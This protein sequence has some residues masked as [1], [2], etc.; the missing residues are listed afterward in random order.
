MATKANIKIKPVYQWSMP[1]LLVSSLILVVILSFLVYNNLTVDYYEKYSSLQN[2]E[3]NLKQQI[4]EKHSSIKKVPI[5][6]A[7]MAELDLL[8]STVNKQFPDDD[9]IPNML[10]Q[11][12]QMAEQSNVAILNM[13]PSVEEKLLSESTPNSTDQNKIWSKSFSVMANSST[14]GFVKFL[15]AI[16]KYPRVLQVSDVKIQRVDDNSINVAMMITIFYVK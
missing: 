6:L 14:E 3:N 11:I 16:A 1:L 7:K 13:L 9:E 10:I 15:Y 5:Y 12:N 4:Y 8:E 2:E